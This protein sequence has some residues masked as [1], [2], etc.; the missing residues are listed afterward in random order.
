MRQFNFE[1]RIMMIRRAALGKLAVTPRGE[2]PPWQSDPSPSFDV[3]IILTNPW[4]KIISI[5][6]KYQ[7]SS[8]LYTPPALSIHWIHT[9]SIFP[10]CFYSIEPPYNIHHWFICWEISQFAYITLN[11][12][13]PWNLEFHH[14]ALLKTFQSFQNYS[15]KFDNK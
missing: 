14:L 12:C 3:V 13:W 15:E 5:H 2:P 7:R 8:R 11:G 1:Q 9:G 6:H 4:I 10:F